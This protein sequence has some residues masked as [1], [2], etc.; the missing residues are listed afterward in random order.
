MESRIDRIAQLFV[1]L[2]TT[3]GT[4]SVGCQQPQAAA[5]SSEPK[6]AEPQ[7]SDPAAASRRDV[8]VQLARDLTKLDRLCWS[9]RID[10]NM[11]MPS[12]SV[13]LVVRYDTGSPSGKGQ[14]FTAQTGREAISAALRAIEG[15]ARPVSAVTVT[16]A[17]M[18]ELSDVLVEVERRCWFLRLEKSSNQWSV[19]AK[20]LRP[21]ALGS[22]TAM[23]QGPGL[24]VALEEVLK[25]LD[26]KAAT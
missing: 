21:G 12:D 16:E 20:E 6:G 17:E 14:E 22:T 1:L 23:A 8:D 25:E 26:R 5:P 4:A 11:E 19:V 15:E 18:F 3:V 7:T 2:L 10:A 13:H 9:I 24:K